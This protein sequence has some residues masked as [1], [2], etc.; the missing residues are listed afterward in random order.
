MSALP[1]SYEAVHRGDD[2]LLLR[3]RRPPAPERARD[4]AAQTRDLEILRALWRY[5]YLLTSQIAREW[6]PGRSLYA[7]QKRLLRLTAAGWVTRFR[8][9]L[10][11]GKHEWVYQLARKG[12]Q[13]AKTFYGELGPY[14]PLEAKWRERHV[15]DYRVVEHD[16]QVNAW[17]MAYRRLADENVTDWLGP[18]DSR[19]DLPTKYVDRR[20]KPIGLEDVRAALPGYLQLRDLRLKHL[21]PLVPDATLQLCFEE[22]DRAFDLMIELDRTRRPVKN[23]DKLRRYDALIT[24]WWRLH[25]R[26]QEREEP[27]AVV[28]VCTDE[29]QTMALMDAADREVTACLSNPGDAPGSWRYPGRERM[30]FVAEQE[31]HEGAGHAWMLPRRSSVELDDL[32][33]RAVNLPACPA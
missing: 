3:D 16:L 21:A 25:E 9:R 18:D 28:F 13:L 27:P 5:R 6:W 19:L 1:D 10:S 22:S 14:V 23:L 2:L 17:V 12:L 29:H 7:A 11:R 15:R 4:L 32:R 30:L 8:P 24:G 26:L 31:I 20:F 33:S